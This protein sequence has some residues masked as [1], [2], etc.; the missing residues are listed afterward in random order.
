MVF[1]YSS[2][3]GNERPGVSNWSGPLSVGYGFRNDGSSYGPELTFGHYIS[4]FFEEDI[5]LIKVAEGGSDLYEKWRSPSME[6][7][8]GV[9]EVESNYPLLAQHLNEVIDDI[10]SFIPKH[11][12]LDIDT[13]VAGFVWFQRYH[14]PYFCSGIRRKPDR[15]YHRPKD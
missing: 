10:G 8:L 3:N 7:R 6:V 11:Q 13:E 4:T 2:R 9:S 12:G 14:Q 15:L 5:V 1:D